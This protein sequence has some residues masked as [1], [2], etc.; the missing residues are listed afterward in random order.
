MNVYCKIARPIFAFM[1][2]SKGHSSEINKLLINNS[3]AKNLFDY[4]DNQTICMFNLNKNL[5]DKN[6]IIPIYL[7][8]TIYEK[9]N[10]KK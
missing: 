7:R 4:S 8:N 10:F 9:L 3:I 1:I 5:I 2:S 6:T